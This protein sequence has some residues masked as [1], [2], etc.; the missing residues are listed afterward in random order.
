MNVMMRQQN[1]LFFIFTIA[2]L[3]HLCFQFPGH[4]PFVCQTHKHTQE[5]SDVNMCLI[6]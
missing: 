4:L 6:T 5:L 3:L 2:K 1:L